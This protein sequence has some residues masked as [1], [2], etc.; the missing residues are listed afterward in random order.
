M[1]VDEEL[2]WLNISYMSL[3]VSCLDISLLLDQF[4][5]E[6]LCSLLFEFVQ[7]IGIIVLLSQSELELELL[8]K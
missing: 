1:R 4:V 6:R 3:Y 5:L 7:C 8:A 2:N